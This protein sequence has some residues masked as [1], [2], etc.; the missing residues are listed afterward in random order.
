MFQTEDPQSATGPFRVRGGGTRCVG[1]WR[2]F[3][4]RWKEFGLRC[5]VLGRF[6]ESPRRQRPTKELR[7]GE[8]AKR[9]G[10]SGKRSADSVLGNCLKQGVLV[11]LGG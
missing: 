4:L 7:V 6:G 2:L 1:V 9:V 5:D 11:P 3:E 10:G 8:N